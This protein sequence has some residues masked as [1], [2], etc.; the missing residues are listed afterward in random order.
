M[1]NSVTMIGRLAK[2]NVF[3]TTAGGTQIC[4]NTLALNRKIKN[5]K[6]AVFIK[7][8]FIGN[9]LCEIMRLYTAK[10]KQIGINGSLDYN[11]WTGQDGKTRYEHSIVVDNIELLGEKINA[12]T[13]RP[14]Q[15]KSANAT[16]A[17]INQWDD[18]IP[19]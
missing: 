9:S 4:E 11:Q 6:K 16:K 14:Q 8:V 18:E 1:I 2:D 15:T 7:V 13:P 12:P 17:E 5:D 10:G 19:F 3:K